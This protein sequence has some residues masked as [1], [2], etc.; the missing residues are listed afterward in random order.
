MNQEYESPPGTM[1]PGAGKKAWDKRG[2]PQFARD[3][4]ALLAILSTL[5]TALAVAGII[6]M[7]PLKTIAPYLIETD[8]T[9]KTVAVGPVKEYNPTQAQIHYET[10]KWTEM[11]WGVDRVL[12]EAN[13]ED[14]YT[15]TR[16][17]AADVFRQY[18]ATY[19]PIER[20]KSDPSLSVAVQVKAVNFLP[21]DKQTALVRFEVTERRKNAKPKIDIYMMT[22]HFAII[23]PKN[24]EEIRENPVGF[25]V[26]DFS[27]SREASRD[28]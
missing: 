14:A 9:G 11:L 2:A 5:T 3:R 1:P 7:L 23:P 12:V 6:F 18:V 10:A 27:W 26:T 25:F 16:G 24:E 15:K 28:E 17:K 22:L 19:R 13:L 4:F 8:S 20:S 21:N